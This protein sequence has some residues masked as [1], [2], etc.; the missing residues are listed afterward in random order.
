M[1]LERVV[2]KFSIFQESV[3]SMY[4]DL[5]NKAQCHEMARHVLNKAI[6]MV[7]EHSMKEVDAVNTQV[8]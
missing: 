8:D 4:Q 5:F 1:H 2:S 7:D 6:K 3:P